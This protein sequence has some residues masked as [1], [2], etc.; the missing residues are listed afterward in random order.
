MA[1]PLDI[2][3]LGSVLPR[4]A[5]RYLAATGWRATTS[6]SVAAVWSR[7]IDGATVEVLL[8]STSDLGDYPARIAD[9]LRTL[10][11]VED[12]DRH[13]ILY[14]LRF[15]L[16]DVTYIRTM[17]E[18]PSGTTL[19]HE[20][21]KAISGVKDLFLAAATTAAP[22][23]RQPVL[24]NTKPQAVWDFMNQVRLGLTRKGS[25]VLRV[26]TL[27]DD[28]D[29]LPVTP[30]NVVRHLYGAT[31]TALNAAEES[32]NRS[33]AAFAEQTEAGVSAHLCEALAEIGGNHRSPFDL[34][35]TW[36]RADPVTDE[37]TPD[38]SFERRHIERLREAGRYLRDLPTIREVTLRGKVI[39]LR[40]TAPD[41]HHGIIEV[42]G[43][44]A[45]EDQPRERQ[46]YL[47]HLPPQ[48]YPLAGSAHLNEKDVVVTGSLRTWG[49]QPEIV[50]VTSF[51]VVTPD[52]LF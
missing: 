32:G 29:R 43:V 12:R 30:R 40:N 5:A 46:K 21:F 45:A 48:H 17:P 42:D 3:E 51:A 20:G 6:Y 52:S 47:V 26:E 24:P 7:E 41:R 25:Y 35:F 18:T 31:R 16:V 15:P 9:V 1:T 44:V 39:A 38:L 28:N 49:R 8:P 27:L 11:V 23:M 14:E 37:E 50:Q 36:S 13:D 2:D 22:E 19:L 4:N 34:S 10:A 33:F